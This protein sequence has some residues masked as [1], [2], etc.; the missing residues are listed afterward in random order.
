MDFG[1]HLGSTGGALRNWVLGRIEG[2][3]GVGVLWLRTL[4]SAYPTS[5]DMGGDRGRTPDRATLCLTEHA[6]LF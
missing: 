5:S 2:S 3:L 4:H 6:S 1:D